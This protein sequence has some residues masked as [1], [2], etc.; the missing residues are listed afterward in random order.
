MLH[1]P[2]ISSVA[3]ADV[4]ADV[5]AALLLLLPDVPPPPLADSLKA[6]E[7]AVALHRKK[8]AAVEKQRQAAAER[9]QQRQAEGGGLFAD[10]EDDEEAEVE[11]YHVPADLLNNT[12]VLLY[13]W[14][15]AGDVKVATERVAAELLLSWAVGCC[16]VLSSCCNAVGGT[17]GSRVDSGVACHGCTM[18]AWPCRQPA[19]MHGDDPQLASYLLRDH[20]MAKPHLS[21]FLLRRPRP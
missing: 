20:T 10:D 9:Q 11:A 7:K 6:Y 12:A 16:A 8:Q 18:A 2:S 3:A 5:A 4:A 19:D 21:S 15:G 14:G 1:L 13:R 17:A